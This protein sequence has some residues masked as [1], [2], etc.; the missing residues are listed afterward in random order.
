MSRIHEALKR[1]AQERST[2]VAAGLEPGILEVKDEIQ[3]SI[4]RPLELERVTESERVISGNHQAVPFRYEDLVRRCAHPEWRLNPHYNAF[5]NSKPGFGGA[6]RFRT[7][8]SRLNQIAATRTLRRLLVTSG[9]AVEGK[10]FVAS[11]LAHSIVR[12]P[13]QRVLLV[14]A[15]LRAP[16]LH[17]ALGAPGYPGLTEYL[18]DQADQYTVIQKGMEENICF[19][20]GGTQVSNPSELLLTDRIKHLLDLLT[21]IFDW[22]IIDSPPVLPVHDASML[23]D[24]VDG[25]LLVCRAGSTDVEHAKSSVAEFQNKNLLGVVL[26][27]VDKSDSYG[28]YY[29]D[30]YAKGT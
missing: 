15:D 21:P 19:I 30:Y 18:Q 10:T 5:Q 26:N 23:A 7:L 4:P 24:M 16:R 27:Q 13:D 25:V 11:N 3:H 1:A 29:S 6:E 20:P 17:V 12:Q 28:D 8:R 22:I 14:D 9:L 2:Q